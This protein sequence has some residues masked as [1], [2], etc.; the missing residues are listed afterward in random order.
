MRAS[1]EAVGVGQFEAA[2]SV[3]M[4]FWQTISRIILPQSLKIAMPM[5]G[6]ALIS[7]IKGTSFLYLVGLRDIT[8]MARIIGLRNGAPFELHAFVGVIYW[9]FC[10]GV[11]RLFSYIEKIMK[12]SGKELPGTERH[13]GPEK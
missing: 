12:K 6:N 11:E 10:F 5:M 1:I 3:G 4:T 9:I 2:R 7:V 8:S 13:R